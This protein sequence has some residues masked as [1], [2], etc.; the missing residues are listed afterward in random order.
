MTGA[1]IHH[2]GPNASLLLGLAYLQALLAENFGRLQDAASA[3][4]RVLDDQARVPL[5]K[6]A[7]HQALGSWQGGRSQ[8][9]RTQSGKHRCA[10]WYLRKAFIRRLTV[11]FGLLPPDEHRQA[12]LGA[13][14]G[15]QGQ[16]CVRDAAHRVELQLLTLHTLVEKT[17]HLAV[18]GEEV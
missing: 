4:H 7:L 8:S 9:V 13:D 16:R 14:D 10:Y 3:G 12:V 15:G 6:L 17:G 5:S 2:F 18:G 1:G 11:V